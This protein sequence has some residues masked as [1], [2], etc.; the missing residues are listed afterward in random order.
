MDESQIVA[1]HVR[2]IGAKPGHI[3]RVSNG[4]VDSLWLVTSVSRDKIGVVRKRSL[5]VAIGN[6]VRRVWNG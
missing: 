1:S 2:D 6:V 3:L 4:K 5:S